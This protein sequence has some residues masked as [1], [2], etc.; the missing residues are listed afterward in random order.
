MTSRPLQ[1]GDR[2]LL[3]RHLPPQ[4]RMLGKRAKWLWTH[5]DFP[6]PLRRTGVSD[7]WSSKAVQRWCAANAAWLETQGERL[8]ILDAVEGLL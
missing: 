4:I 1:P 6:A 5:G 7:C 3:W 2:P 8:A